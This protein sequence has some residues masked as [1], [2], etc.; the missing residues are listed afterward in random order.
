M[1]AGN[2]NYRLAKSLP[3]AVPVF[4]LSAALLLPGGRM[5]LNIFEP[6]YLQMVDEAMAGSRLVGMIQ[7][8][9]D[10][11]L[12][13]DGEPEICSVGCIGRIT[14]L[15]ETGD[16]RYLV[17]LQG[18]CRFRVAEELAVRTPF[19]QCRIVPFVAD[20]DEDRAAAEVNRPALLKAFRSYLDANGLEADWDSVS[21]A[22]NAMLVNALSMMA[23][24]GPAE[25]QALLEAP[26]LKTRADTLIA[27][28]EMALARDNDDFGS[29]LQ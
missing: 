1:Q 13:P 27:L 24:Y 25:K 10:G 16:G 18:V 11:A 4:P 23:P 21:R 5:P 2:V 15:S 26:D 28:T 20:L 3:S 19:R 22:E 8:A 29:S 7:P 14:S 9:L 12:R 6:R 17:S